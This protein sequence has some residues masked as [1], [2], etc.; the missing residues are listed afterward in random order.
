[1]K[2]IRSMS[3]CICIII[4]NMSFSDT[5]LQAWTTTGYIFKYLSYK[6]AL[7]ILDCKINLIILNL[8]N[9]CNLNLEIL[10][11][12][13]VSWLYMYTY[14]YRSYIYAPCKIDVSHQYM[15]H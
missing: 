8:Y 7:Y 12:Y 10:V 14:V 4:M 15:Y 6:F 1:M 3:M 13:S 5:L 9:V 11:S 2:N